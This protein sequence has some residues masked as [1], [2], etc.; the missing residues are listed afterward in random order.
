MKPP[1]FFDDMQGFTFAGHLLYHLSHA[2]VVF[3]FCYIVYSV[4]FLPELVWTMILLY[5]SYVAGMTD[6]PNYWLRW[7]WLTFC[8]GSL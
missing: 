1:P 5:A 8:L 7:V 3:A 2:Q 4:T 6:V